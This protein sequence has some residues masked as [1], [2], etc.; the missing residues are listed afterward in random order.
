MLIPN[1]ETREGMSVTFWLLMAVV[2]V[3]VVIGVIVYGTY[4][5][6]INIERGAVQHSN[7]YTQSKVT[8]LSDLKAQY[9]D[10]DTKIVL[11]KDNE[12]VVTAYK[13][14]QIAILQQMW[15]A[16]DLIP[17]DIV[18]DVV[19]NNIKAFLNAHPQ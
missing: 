10:L 9:T 19:P 4:Q 16:Y 11:Y 14:Q 5:T 2:A 3:L 12:D 17:V 18:S 6:R 15:Q 7:Q 13:A 8:Q 1:R